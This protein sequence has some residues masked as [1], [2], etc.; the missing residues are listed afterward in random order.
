LFNYCRNLWASNALAAAGA[1]AFVGLAFGGFSPIF[2]AGCGTI[3]FATSL[4]YN[5]KH[6]NDKKS[7]KHVNREFFGTGLGDVLNPFGIKHSSVK[8]G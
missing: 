3:S 8:E 6:R 4:A 1:G 7:F 2:L 5:I